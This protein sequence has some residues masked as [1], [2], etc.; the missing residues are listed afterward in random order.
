VAKKKITIA[1][2]AYNEAGVLPSF[3]EEI[4]KV[5]FQRTE[6]GE[7]LAD[8]YVFS[9]LI[10]NDGSTDDTLSVLM[11]YEGGLV[12]RVVDMSRNYGHIAACT[13]CLDYM[14]G[15]ALILMDSDLQDDPAAIVDFIAQ[16]EQGYDVVYAMRTNREETRIYKMLFTAFYHILNFFVDVKIPL[17]AGNFSLMDKR[18]VE[19]IKSIPLRNRYLPGVRAYIGF[20]QTGV[21]VPRRGRHDR[22]SRVGIKGLF[23]LAFTGIFSFSYVPIRLFNIL[24][25]LSLTISFCLM[26]YALWGKLIGHTAVTAWASQIITVSFFGGINIL[27]LGIIGEY[28]A[29]IYDQIRGYPVYIVNDITVLCNHG[30]KM[31]R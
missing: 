23:R 22:K 12:L 8:R 16:W 17:N 20:R 19:H 13:A 4:E 25:G 11:R 1:A 3:L 30:E 14:D 18:I 5:L 31:A 21:P 2:P 24:G 29:R 28:I 26:L 15:D 6:R 27:G 7:A 10:V 9:I